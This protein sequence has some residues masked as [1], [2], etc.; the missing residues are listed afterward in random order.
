LPDS[1]IFRTQ[2]YGPDQVIPDLVGEDAKGIQ[3]LI[4]EAKFWA[5]LTE[6]Q[7]VQ[8]LQR[9]QQ[10]GTGTLAFIVPA[11]RAALLW[12]ELLRR[13]LSAG[14]RVAD[15][16][17]VG[18]SS[19]FGTVRAGGNLCLLSWNSF[20]ERVRSELERAGEQLV[21]A[22]LAQIQG[23]CEREDAKA[24]LPLASE[25]LTGTT[26][27]RLIQFGELVDDITEHLVKKGV[28]D[29][30]RF[31]STAGNGRYGKYM[32]THGFGCFLQFSAWNWRDRD[33]TPL[34]LTI[35]GPEWK[36]NPHLME[37][38][39][40]LAKAKNIPVVPIDQS[41]EFP[42]FLPTRVEREQVFKD[43]L[44]QLDVTIQCLHDL[45]SRKQAR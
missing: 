34:W 40:R 26:A 13:C 10:Q 24:F 25:E 11:Q 35:D 17:V 33:A 36:P 16:S 18:S 2:A 20:I 31:K 38:L 3:H 42:L 39:L 37:Q 44:D 15:T 32:L 21:V 22:D 6:S 4:I 27:Q 43:I 28:A 1:L 23:L 14:I 30:K 8:Y 9:I 19:R 5:G 12:N 29:T 45:K 7:P 41:V